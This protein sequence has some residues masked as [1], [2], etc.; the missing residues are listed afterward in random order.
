MTPVLIGPVRGLWVV[1]W[2]GKIGGFWLYA[3]ASV[4]T[5]LGL[6]VGLGGCRA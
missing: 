3:F 1:E 6:V 2:V 4:L 5:L